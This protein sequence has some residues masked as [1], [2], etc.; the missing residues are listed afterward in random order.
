M[1]CKVTFT[2]RA[3]RDRSRCRAATLVEYLFAIAI[4]SLLLTTVS[5]FAMHHAKTAAMLSNMIDMDQANRN[6]QSQMSRDFRQAR[7]QPPAVAINH[8]TL[9][10]REFPGSCNG[11]NDSICDLNRP[12]FKNMAGSHV[13]D[14]DRRDD[15]GFAKQG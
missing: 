7:Y 3:A 13:D 15:Q 6:A 11:G 4:G 12:V 1:V 5:L 9:I 10:G 8:R 14:V 2:N